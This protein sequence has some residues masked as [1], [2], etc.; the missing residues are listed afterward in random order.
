MTPYEYA[1]IENAR[2]RERADGCPW[3]DK[4]I[5]TGRPK[6]VVPTREREATLLNLIKAKPGRTAA[7]L[8]AEVGL[9]VNQWSNVIRN[10]K[11]TRLV[12]SRRESNNSTTWWP[13]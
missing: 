12:V 6:V 13:K 3:G 11:G 10:L 9:S 7:V 2:M 5:V 1:Q 8:R 4:S